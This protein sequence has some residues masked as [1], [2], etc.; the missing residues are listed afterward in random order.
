MI[1]DVFTASVAFLNIIYLEYFWLNSSFSYAT[2]NLKSFYK[3][4]KA[5][6]FE[7]LGWRGSCV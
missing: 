4:A 7:N 6:S 3:L 2:I 1:S 5:S